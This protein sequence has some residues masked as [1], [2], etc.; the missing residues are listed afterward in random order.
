MF[1]IGDRVKCIKAYDGKNTLGKLGKVIGTNHGN[2]G[3]EFDDN[4]DGH[5]CSINGNGK[6]GHCWNFPMKGNYLE[7]V[8]EEVK[9]EL[10]VNKPKTET[11]VITN[12]GK[13]TTATL[14]NGKT[15]LN[16]AT[17]ICCPTDEFSAY[18]GARI[19]LARLFGEEAF[20]VPVKSD[21]TEMPTVETISERLRVG[22]RVSYKGDTGTIIYDDKTT[23]PYLVEFDKERPTYHNGQGRGK[24]HRCYWLHEHDVIKSSTPKPEEKIQTATAYGIPLTEYTEVNRHAKVGDVVKIV[25]PEFAIG[26]TKG[27]IFIVEAMRKTDGV[28]DSPYWIAPREYTAN[29]VYE[30]ILK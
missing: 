25:A 27:D 1:K 22:D 6:N 9:L 12:D 19:A 5:S 17:S 13:T 2:Y 21:Y 29:K 3:V 20:S 28:I 8:K 14:R 23:C 10:V 4:I 15:V 24:E 16:K 26:Y 11:I 30:F 18:E 7:L